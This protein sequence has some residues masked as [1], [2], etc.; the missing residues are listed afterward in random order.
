LGTILRARGH[1]SVQSSASPGAGR[2]VSLTVGLHCA[3]EWKAVYNKRVS[4]EH[5]FS[6]L[7]GYRKLNG[8]RARRMPKVWLHIALSLL[9][10]TGERTHHH[11]NGVPTRKCIA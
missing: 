2:A 3:R 8:I 10:T 7:E 1:D 4:V 6:R 11:A 9:T 5:V